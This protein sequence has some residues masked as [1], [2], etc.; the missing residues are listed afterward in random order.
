M[1]STGGVVEHEAGERR[2][3]KRRGWG[4]GESGTAK[5]RFRFR[6]PRYRGTN[7]CH[8]VHGGVGTRVA[9]KHNRRGSDAAP[10]PPHRCEVQESVENWEG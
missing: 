8:V 4:W 3:E 10:G 9:T 2:M 6:G 7:L 1:G 5:V